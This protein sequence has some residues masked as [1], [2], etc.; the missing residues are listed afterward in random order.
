MDKS[1]LG[2]ILAFAGIIVALFPIGT[3]N[4][5]AMAIFIPMGIIM[6]YFSTKM[7]FGGEE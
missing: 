3:A 7:C 1:T 2:G 5:L 4:P 6:I